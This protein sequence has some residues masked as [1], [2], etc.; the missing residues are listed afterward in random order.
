[1]K[2]YVFII[3]L[4]FGVSTLLSAETRNWKPYTIE[5]GKF[6]I[7]L[8]GMPEESTETIKTNAGD[9]PLYTLNYETETMAFIV[10][11]YIYPD[12]LLTPETSGELF[13]NIQT[14]SLQAWNGELIEAKD[15]QMDNFPGRQIRLQSKTSGEYFHIHLVLVKNRLYQIIAASPAKEEPDV[16]AF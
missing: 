13:D 9:I 15:V 10:N 5:N 3:A 4:L 6:T 2:N 12:G 7:K 8:P 11:M 16:Q 1:M 14:N